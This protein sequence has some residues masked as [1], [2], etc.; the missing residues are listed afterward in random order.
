MKG[1]RKKSV[2]PELTMGPVLFHW[3]EEKWRDFYYRVADEAPVDRVFIGET[4]CA[5]R[6]AFTEP[7]YDDV[8]QRLS[9]A[10]KK[11]VF[12]TLGEVTV[13]LDRRCV[14]GL[15]SLENALVEAN[16]ASSLWALS[17]RPHTAG[18]LLNVYN[19][20]TLI[21]LSKSGVTRFCLPPELPRDSISHL[22]EVAR[23]RK[24]LIEVQVYGR[25]PL[26]LSARCYHARAHGRTKDSCQFVC[27]NDLDGME[28]K[29]LSGK[30]FLCI[31][32][33]ETM[34][35]NCL[36]LAQ[37][38]PDLVKAGVGALRLSPHSHDMVETSRLFRRLIAGN[39]E[40]AETVH[41]LS[42]ISGFPFS[43]G[44]YHKKEG[45]RWVASGKKTA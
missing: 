9:R 27:G 14:E 18:P 19:E 31:N 38:I 35:Y 20:E 16:D 33:I 4:V 44:F 34:S 30:P 21:H 5:K 13:R 41:R 17:G 32:G 43:N 28:L 29:T 2:H 8:A 39:I 12:S 23:K 25:I 40:A 37:E 36:N 45:F 22:C 15:C 1:M 7:Y 11:V 24:V 3:P 42:E 26:A 6:A 10:G